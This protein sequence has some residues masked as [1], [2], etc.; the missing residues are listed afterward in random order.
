MDDSPL[1]VLR[2]A[3]KNLISQIE[4]RY[5]PNAAGAARLL[6]WNW[7][8]EPVLPEDAMAAFERL[9]VLGVLG[10]GA[11]I[12]STIAAKDRERLAPLAAM[13]PERRDYDA[14]IQ[15]LEDYI[16]GFS[17]VDDTDTMSARIYISLSSSSSLLLSLSL[18][19]KKN[20]E[21]PMV[22]MVVV[23]GMGM[24][25]VIEIAVTMGI[26]C[27]LL[28]LVGWFLSETNLPRN[29][30]ASALEDLPQA[31]PQMKR[32]ANSERKITNGKS[33]NVKE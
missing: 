25:M 18:L 21:M 31:G 22:M 26:V 4:E 33:G 16:D 20:E 19:N 12:T 2:K 7:F 32:I 8:V 30:L 1:K 9:R 17:S 3:A 10:Y 28:I 6:P 29:P 27:V 23:M 13:V 24:G 15:A 14:L 5:P 11:R